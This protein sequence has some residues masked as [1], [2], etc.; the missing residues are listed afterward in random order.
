MPQKIDILCLAD[1]GPGIH[2]GFAKVFSEIKNGVKAVMRDRIN[3]SVI[4]I[5]YDGTHY[6]EKDGTE[7][8][9]AI[10]S[11][12]DPTFYD[13]FGRVGFLKNLGLGRFDG[14]FILHD[15]GTILPYGPLI[16]KTNQDFD[17]VKRRNF[18]SIFY[19][20]IDAEIHADMLKHIDVFNCLVTYNEFGRQQIINHRPDLRKK[21]KVVPHGTDTD[22]FFP[23]RDSSRRLFREQYFGKHADK[24]IICNVNRN[25]H[26]KDISATLFSFAEYHKTAPNSILYLHMHPMD[27]MGWDIRA[28]ASGLNLKEGVDYVFPPMQIIEKEGKKYEDYQCDETT[29]N[30]IYNA[31]DVYFT[32]T[33]GEGWGLGVTEAMACKLP[34]I[35]PLNTSLIEITDNG[36]RA[37]VLENQYPI[38]D[39]ADSV[40]RSQVDPDEAAHQLDIVEMHIAMEDEELTKKV[41]AAYKYA[42]SLQWAD[43]AK[44]WVEIFKEIY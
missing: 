12:D 2:T 40:Y 30:K 28:L 38:A 36:N 20:P 8:C 27:P 19:F 16:K 35:C 31:C 33:R 22:T 42:T 26:R 29:L 41:E 39:T 7:V 32:T 10:Y 21:I 43:I 5:N 6:V 9:A 4:A 25:Q 3:F 23:I 15:I 13:E 11:A 24:Y 18:K 14:I 37:Y 34:V 44:R 1:Y 17:L